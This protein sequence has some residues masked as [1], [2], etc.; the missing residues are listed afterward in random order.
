[1]K[2][3]FHGAKLTFLSLS[4]IKKAALFI[5]RLFKVLANLQGI[6]LKQT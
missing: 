6:S 3:A 4:N 5:E 2:L 1:M